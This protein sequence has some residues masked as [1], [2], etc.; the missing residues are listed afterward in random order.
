M[1]RQQSDPGTPGKQVP[2][3]D[4]DC[5]GTILIHRDPRRCVC[6]VCRRRVPGAE[7]VTK[8]VILF[9]T[10]LALALVAALA[11]AVWMLTLKH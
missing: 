8:S 1:G 4:R 11:L 5:P 7:A 9:V 10:L 6:S 3:W 2:C